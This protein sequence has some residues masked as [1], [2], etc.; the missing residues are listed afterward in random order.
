MFQNDIIYLELYHDILGPFCMT[1][2]TK[3]CKYIVAEAILIKKH[4]LTFRECHRIV[5]SAFSNII[6]H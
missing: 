2:I 5:L 4:S 6:N 1:F 3:C